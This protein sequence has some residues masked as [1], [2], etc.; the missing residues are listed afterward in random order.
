MGCHMYRCLSMSLNSIEWGQ[1]M[2]EEMDARVHEVGTI[3][4]IIGGRSYRALLLGNH[5]SSQ[6]I[7]TINMMINNCS[8]KIFGKLVSTNN[9]HRKNPSLK[10]VT[11]CRNITVPVTQ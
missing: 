1:E 7:P 9:K 3:V 4:L 2:L 5:Y 10:E 8:V 11:K 6:Y